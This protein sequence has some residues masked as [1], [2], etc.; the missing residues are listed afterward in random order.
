[1]EALLA[2]S[3]A[4]HWNATGDEDGFGY[5]SALRL[6]QEAEESRRRPG[7]LPTDV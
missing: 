5:R 1:M 3:E 7:T 6:L 4:V 2:G